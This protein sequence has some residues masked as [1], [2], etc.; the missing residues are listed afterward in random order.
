MKATE[1][2]HLTANTSTSPPKASI[3]I[4]WQPPP[5]NHIKINTDGSHNQL[6]NF[7][8]CGGIIRDENGNWL[9]GFTKFLGYGDALLAELWGIK[10]GLQICFDNHFSN[11]IFESDSLLAVNL[12]T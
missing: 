7:I 2:Y 4:S 9:C 11:V 6:S 10:T 3:L 1:F 12:I 5:P 8:A